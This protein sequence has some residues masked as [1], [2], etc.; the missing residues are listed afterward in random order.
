M[1]LS[2]KPAQI[3]S[4]TSSRCHVFRLQ[5][6]SIP[7]PSVSLSL[8]LRCTFLL[9]ASEP[10]KL[11][12]K[13]EW[14]ILEMKPQQI[15]E[16]DADA[17]V[18]RNINRVLAYWTQRVSVGVLSLV[19]HIATQLSVFAHCAR[20]WTLG[21]TKMISQRFTSQFLFLYTYSMRSVCVP[22]KCYFHTQTED[23]TERQSEKQRKLHW[24]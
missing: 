6:P 3:E 17:A 11:P 7:H 10:F 13:E 9:F 2:L 23:R 4:S 24:L 15:T 14:I 20:L 16:S 21:A 18:K 8:V 12:N 5:C 1:W 22:A 19:Q